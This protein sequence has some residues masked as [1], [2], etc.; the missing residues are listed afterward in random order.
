MRPRIVEWL[1]ALIGTGPAEWLVP[2]PITFYGVAMLAMLLVFLRRGQA[3]GR[4]TSDLAGAGFCAMVGGIVGARVFYLIQ[5]DLLL[6][7]A[8]LRYAL[9]SG[10]TASWGAYLGSVIGLAVYHRLTVR[11]LL[12]ALDLGASV[13][14]L[15]IAIG[16]LSCFLNGD[17][18]GTIT[19]VPW[20]V[21]FPHGSF[22]FAAQVRAGILD[23]AADLSLGVHPVQLY[24]GLNGLVLFWIASMA[25]RR[26]RD[27]PGLTFASFVVLYSVTRFGIEFF[28]GDQ[29]RYFG[30]QLSAPQVMCLA[31]LS[32]CVM[33]AVGARVARLRQASRQRSAAVGAA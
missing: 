5:H 30:Q 22:P 21:R 15:G 24:L 26:F 25:W 13:A 32:G 33:V 29:A 6:H 8:T 2:D 31:T 1:A 10:G 14:G 3:L 23:S 17:D 4:S 28:R 27:R 11:P 19:H 20:S 12:P 18:Y 16:R 7:P 9:T